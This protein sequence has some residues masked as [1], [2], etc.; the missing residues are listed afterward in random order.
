MKAIPNTASN[1]RNLNGAL[2]DVTE[3]T[4]GHVECLIPEDLAEESWGEFHALFKKDEV[5]LVCE[6]GEMSR[7]IYPPLILN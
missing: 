5:T 6:P 3:E 2:L 1:Y 4:V 7:L